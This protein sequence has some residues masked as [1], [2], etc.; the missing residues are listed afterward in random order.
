MHVRQAAHQPRQVPLGLPYQDPDSLTLQTEGVKPTTQ[1]RQVKE[2]PCQSDEQSAPLCPFLLLHRGR[3]RIDRRHQM[4]S[5]QT[6][7]V[8]RTTNQAVGLKHANNPEIALNLAPRRSLALPWCQYSLFLPATA[9][10]VRWVWWVPHHCLCLPRHPLFLLPNHHHCAV[11]QTPHG[12]A[13]RAA[14]IAGPLPWWL[15]LYLHRCCTRSP[16]FRVSIVARNTL[17]MSF[18]T[19]AHVAKAV[20]M[21]SA[22]VA[23]VKEKDAR[24]GLA[25]GGQ[26]GGDMHSRHLKEV[27]RPVR[28]NRMSSSVP[29]IRDPQRRLPNPPLHLMR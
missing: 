19:T 18:T 3:S 12:L 13:R 9:Q 20:R 6:G 25:S 4:L 27:I 10:P 23:T 24:T 29:A 26:H 1:G 8:N 11:R 5:R 17:S 28:R 16:W 14:P 2:V 15:V 22:C 7:V 21:I